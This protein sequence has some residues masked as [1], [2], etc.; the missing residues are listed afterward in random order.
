MYIW[1]NRHQNQHQHI[2]I[3]A[4]TIKTSPI[5]C[6]KIHQQHICTYTYIIHQYIWI[7]AYTI[8]S[9][10]IACKK[11]HQQHICTYTYII[12]NNI[13]IIIQ[14]LHKILIIQVKEKDTTH[15]D[16]HHI[17][18]LSIIHISPYSYIKPIIKVIQGNRALRLNSTKFVS[19]F[20]TLKHYDNRTKTK[21]INSISSTM[22]TH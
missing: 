5:T 16:R 14:R 21:Q 1:H 8:K 9:S 15:Y 10:P 3:H 19:Y 12:T 17:Q 4:Y 20:T 7:H 22:Y 11:I 13:T 6:K 2:L 18:H